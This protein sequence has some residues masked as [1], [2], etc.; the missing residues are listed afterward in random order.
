[1]YYA[2]ITVADDNTILNSKNY[3]LLVHRCTYKFTC[4]AVCTIYKILLKT[5][6]TAMMANL[7]F[8]VVP[9]SNEVWHYMFA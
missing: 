7:P 9:Y 6:N 4:Q 3:Y 8:T 1:M 5:V 2:R